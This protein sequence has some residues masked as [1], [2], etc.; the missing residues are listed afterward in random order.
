MPDYV[1]FYV[2]N[3]YIG[4]YINHNYMPL[5]VFVEDTK[6]KHNLPKYQLNT[7]YVLSI[8]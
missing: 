5:Q 6:V 2:S 7:A 8:I 4:V 3:I 1:T